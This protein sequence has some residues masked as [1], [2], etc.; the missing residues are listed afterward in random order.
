M[1]LRPLNDRILVKRVEEETKTKAESLFPTRPRKNRPR[2]KS[3]PSAT[4]SSPMTERESR[5]SS[6]RETGFFLESTPEPRLK[7]TAKNT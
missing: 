1:K 2:G 3:S 5:S 6:R 7:W 4:A